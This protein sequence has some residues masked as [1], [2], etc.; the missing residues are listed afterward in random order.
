[1]ALLCLFVEGEHGAKAHVGRRR[2]GRLDQGPQRLGPQVADGTV[3]G[4]VDDV[5]LNHL[6]G[7]SIVGQV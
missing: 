5:G 3:D 1:M 2:R 4:L 6:T 7:S